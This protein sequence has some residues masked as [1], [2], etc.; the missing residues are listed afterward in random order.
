MEYLYS[1]RLSP[2]KVLITLK[3]EKGNLILIMEKPGG[4]PQQVANLM[5]SVMRQGETMCHLIDAMKL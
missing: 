4:H 5:S 1:I 2:H 3:A